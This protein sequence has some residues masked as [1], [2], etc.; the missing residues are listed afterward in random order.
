MMLDFGALPP[1]VN[2]GRIYSGPGSG[3]LTAAAAAWDGLANALD[4]AARGYSSAIARLQGESWSGAASVA[5][6]GAATPYIAWMSTAVT[7]AEEAGSRARAAAAAYESVF[8][9]TVP[10]AIVTANRTRYATLVATNLLGQ[11]TAMIADTEADYE[12]MW[13]QD[14][15]AMY[16]YA[17]SSSAASTLTPFNEPPQTTNAPGESARAAAD[18]TA[19]TAR[20]TLAE[21][22]SSVPQQLRSLASMGSA[23]S[24]ASAVPTPLLN[25]FNAF[26]AL[27]APVN[28]GDGISRTYTSAGS[29]GTGLQRVGLQSAAEAAKGARGAAGAAGPAGSAGGGRPVTAGAGSAT[30]V[31]KLSVPQSWASTNPPAATAAEPDWLS[32][33]ELDGGPSWHEVP[34]TNMWNGV[35][36][37]G[38]GASS[39]LLS[40]PTV[41]N[42][43]RLAPRQFKMPRPSAGG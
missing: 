14:A 28:L 9:A 2:S 27:T 17:A 36:P 7:Q 42:L 13:A 19:G 10:P 3:P 20:T 40:R 34:A 37:A 11:N 15:A 8:A 4:S 26:N 38:A 24:P 43:L 12:R 31:G 39:G 41:N 6:A 25:A 30:K 1:E 5:M 22:M 29:F 33:A 16:T 21:L 23:G 18:S 32:D 35:P